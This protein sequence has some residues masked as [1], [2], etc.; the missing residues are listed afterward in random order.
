MRHNFGPLDLVIVLPPF[1]HQAAIGVKQGELTPT[2][3]EMSQGKMTSSSEVAVALWRSNTQCWFST[4][5]FVAQDGKYC[6][7]ALVN[8]DSYGQEYNLPLV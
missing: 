3:I 1:M 7:E 4:F 8:G 6:I 5:D 2:P